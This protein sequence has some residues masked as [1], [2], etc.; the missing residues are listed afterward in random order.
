M[1][2]SNGLTPEHFYHHSS[3]I[4]G[5]NTIVGILCTNLG[6]FY[7]SPNPSY[8]GPPLELWFSTLAAQLNNSKKLLSIHYF[9]QTESKI[10]GTG[11][12]HF[13][14]APQMILMS[15]EGWEP[16]NYW[17]LLTVLTHSSS[18]GIMWDKELCMFVLS[19][20]PLG[21]FLLLDCFCL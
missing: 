13:S 4:W 17:L 12:K 14:G 20:E 16:L 10:L 19:S 6:G 8:V 3:I 9:R 11:P 15:R 5:R 7:H 18:Q 2:L 1:M 21:L